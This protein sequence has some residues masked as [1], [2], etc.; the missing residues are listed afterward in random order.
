M[1]KIF[2]AVLMVLLVVGVSFATTITDK[3]TY[4]GNVIFKGGVNFTGSTVFVDEDNMVS[5]SAVKVPSQQS[6]KAYVD[7]VQTWAVPLGGLFVDGTGP[8]TSSTAPNLTT[9]DNVGAVVYDNSGEVAEIQFSY[10]PSTYFAG[11]TV[12]I[13]ATSSVATGSQQAVDWSIFVHKDDTALPV[14]VAQT[15]A[16]YTSA[17]MD[18]SVDVVTLTLDATGI[19]AITGGTSLVTVAIW[20]NGTSNGTLEI[21]GIKVTEL[22]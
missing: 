11:M 4:E 14:V 15:G 1:K 5:D 7:A 21:K 19:A 12:K 6:V 3:M 9:V 10:A 17:K 16:A 22:K 8:I 13:F 2:M 18:T 20:N